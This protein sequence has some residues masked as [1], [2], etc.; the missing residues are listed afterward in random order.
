MKRLHS[1]D[2]EQVLTTIVKF[3]GRGRRSSWQ[4]LGEVCEK[5]IEAAA[6]PRFPNTM[7]ALSACRRSRKGCFIM[8]A[9]TGILG[10]LCVAESSS[11]NTAGIFMDAA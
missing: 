9:V 11:E 10:R 6:F 1:H 2:F 4:R 7:A 3:D 5:L 8:G